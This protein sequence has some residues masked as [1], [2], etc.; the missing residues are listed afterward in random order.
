MRDVIPCTGRLPHLHSN[1]Q[2]IL[3]RRSGT[4][5]KDEIMHEDTCRSALVLSMTNR[6][7]GLTIRACGRHTFISAPEKR[8]RAIPIR[9]DG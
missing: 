8:V 3:M 5:E 9:L 4:H 7:P 6:D 2:E 1:E